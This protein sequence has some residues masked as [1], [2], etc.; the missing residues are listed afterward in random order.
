MLTDMN[1]NP[2]TETRWDFID[3]GIQAFWAKYPY[4]RDA[5]LQNLS[6]N[7]TEFGLAPNTIE[8]KD[9]RGAGFRNILAFPTIEDGQGNTLDSLQPFIMKHL[10]GLTKKGKWGG[11]QKLLKE[12]MR[13]YPMFC[14]SE[15]Y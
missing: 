7:K 10:P 4:A 15:K 5:W 12:F 2:M 3:T 9:L 6:Q 14:T 1:G 8:H 13:R 11:Q